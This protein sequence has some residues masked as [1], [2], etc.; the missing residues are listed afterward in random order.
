M[1]IMSQNSQVK[2]AITN[3]T[4]QLYLCMYIYVK[5]EIKVKSVHTQSALETIK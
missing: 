1:Y 4:T 2:L 3:E 5:N